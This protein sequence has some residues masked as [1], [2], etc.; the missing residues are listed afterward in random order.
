[1]TFENHLARETS[2]YLLQHKENPVHWFPWGDKAFAAAQAE[3]KPILLSVGYAACH[4]CHVMAHESF[5]QEAIAK[6]MN[7]H[8]INIKV[9]REERPDIDLIYQGALNL[10][11]EQGGW[12]LTMFLTP[13]GKPFWGGTY[14]PPEPR[15]NRPGFPQVLLGLSRAY[16]EAPDDVNKNVEALSHGLAQITRSNPGQ[17][18]TAATIETVT[19]RLIPLLDR[20]WGGSKGA[21]K[22]PQIPLLKFLW[23]QGGGKDPFL[24]RPF[25]I[26][27]LTQLCQGGIYD[28]LGGG[29]ARYCVDQRWLVPHFE[30]ML[31][32]NAQLIDLLTWVH[33]EN[34]TPLFQQRIEQTID[35]L[36]RE[37]QALDHDGRTPCGAFAASLDADSEGQEGRFYVWRE[38]EIDALLGSDAG[39]FKT[40]YDV[41]PEGNWEGTTILNRLRQPNLGA[42]AQEAALAQARRRLL[43]ARDARERPA[44]DDKVLTD[45]NGLTITAL[46]H[47]ARALDRP[48]WLDAAQ[49]AFAFIQTHATKN[50]RLQHSWRRGRAQ[51]NATVDD[52]AFMSE[53]ALALYEASLD[54]RYLAQAASWM[55]CL[56]KDY[57][58]ADG[59]GGFFLT[60]D[61]TT[62]L[63]LRPKTAQDTATPSGNAVAADC[64]ARLY[65]QTGDDIHRQR[66]E[67]VISAFSGDIQKHTVAFTGLLYAAK[68]LAQGLQIVLL[69]DR[70]SPAMT[71][72]RGV[73]DGFS[74][75]AAVLQQVAPGQSL[76][77]G[78]PAAD[79]VE[80]AVE[81]GQ[82]LAFVCQNQRCSLALSTPEQLKTELA[83]CQS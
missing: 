30:K 71:A 23:R 66:A 37:M 24:L 61:D 67:T 45:W 64:L 65:Y 11:G 7:D 62:H 12:P 58:D 38:A 79:K 74:L 76:P 50:G 51:H 42:A 22:F 31:Y 72:L 8:F 60:A 20:K 14:F 81:Q 59:G 52:Y 35:W 26:H 69:G 15:F 39:L 33:Q 49:T 55:A 44:W 6:L 46:T 32:D 83:Q 47:A 68:T 43:A 73:V 3:N 40:H 17:V 4:W 53:A 48:D 21:P 54:R 9:D 10:L 70:E 78:H 19:Q 56:Q 75:P 13:T 27:T 80:A 34:P 36:L 28:H 82:A 29:F 63:P 41:T 25:V 5:E 77:S 57:W 2:P 1:M 18:V 16:Q